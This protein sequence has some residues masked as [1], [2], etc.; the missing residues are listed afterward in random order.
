MASVQNSNDGYVFPRSYAATSR[1]VGSASVR[2]GSTHV[3]LTNLDVT[4]C[5]LNYQL[6]LWQKAWGFYFQ[7]SIKH[8]PSG[9][10]IADVTTRSGC[11]YLSSAWHTG[12]DDWLWIV[13]GS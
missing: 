3:S 2:I 8:L 12:L 4:G 5:S 9:A 1:Q 11:V 6:Y 7:P 10:C 13:A